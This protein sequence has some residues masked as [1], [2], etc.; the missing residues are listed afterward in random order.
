MKNKA[1]KSS[2]TDTGW[3]TKKL[4]AYVILMKQNV[5][6]RRVKQKKQ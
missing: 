1:G 5:D 2:S 4:L 6:H 3:Q